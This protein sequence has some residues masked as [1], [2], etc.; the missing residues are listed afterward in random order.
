MGDPFN[1]YYYYQH[2]HKK[3][4]IAGYLSKVV[5][6]KRTQDYIYG[7]F[8]AD[9]V[10][11]RL[12]DLK[13]VKFNNMVDMENIEGIKSS[14][15][16]Y[17]ILHKHLTAEMFPY[18]RIDKAQLNYAVVYLIKLYRKYLGKPFFEDKN[19]IVFRIC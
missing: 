8:P 2:F 11:S 14:T 12:L 13:K 9:Y 17:I 7:N 5:I 6:P 4:I 15:A 1:L 19:I 18:L 16:N 3:N 10:M